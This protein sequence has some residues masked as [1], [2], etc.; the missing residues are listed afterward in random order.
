MLYTAGRCLK[1]RKV[2]QGTMESAQRAM[3]S[4]PKWVAGLAQLNKMEALDEGVQTERYLPGYQAT[5]RS[6]S[7]RHFRIM[8]SSNTW[9]SKLCST[10]SWADQYAWAI[11]DIN[12]SLFP[13]I[14]SIPFGTAS[15][16]SSRRSAPE[17]E[18]PSNK[19]HLTA[20]L[21]PSTSLIRS[22]WRLHEWLCWIFFFYSHSPP[23]PVMN[24]FTAYY[25]GLDLWQNSAGTNNLV[26]QHLS[27]DSSITVRGPNLNRKVHLTAGPWTD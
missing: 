21:G 13:H 22:P 5:F 8:D 23:R 16:D 12:T 19:S 18:L 26:C 17:A 11:P 20:F 14:L 6:E 15:H 24:K 3:S 7:S 25:F 9:S 10:S 27:Q 2:A 1:Q 4:D